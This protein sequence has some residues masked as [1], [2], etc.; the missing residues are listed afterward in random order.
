M[1]ILAFEKTTENTDTSHIKF[2]NLPMLKLVV[3]PNA[4][5]FEMETSSGKV[6]YLLKV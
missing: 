4:Y 2:T 1:R 6:K 5:P 3:R